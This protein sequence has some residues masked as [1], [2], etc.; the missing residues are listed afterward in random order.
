MRRPATYF[1]T[2]L[3]GLASTNIPKTL[4]YTQYR[5]FFVTQ[6]PYHSIKLMS[7]PEKDPKD[8]LM[9]RPATYFVTYLN[10]YK[11]PKNIKLYTIQTVMCHTGNISCNKFDYQVLKK[12]PRMS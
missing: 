6:V 2:V 3:N 4:N 5:V 11:S 1:A 9:R 10:F 7:S 12:I 8:F